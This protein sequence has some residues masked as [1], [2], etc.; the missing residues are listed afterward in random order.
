LCKY[1]ERNQENL[2][3]GRDCNESV[4]FEALELKKLSEVYKRKQKLKATEVR[5]KNPKDI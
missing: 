4:C 2:V 1:V 3:V 5:D